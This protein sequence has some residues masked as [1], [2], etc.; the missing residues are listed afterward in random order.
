M[1]SHE[2][3]PNRHRDDSDTDDSGDRQFEFFHLEQFLQ[4]RGYIESKYHLFH[5]L[6][7]DR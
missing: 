7:E 5:L 2:V 3:E 1:F 4:K 6:A